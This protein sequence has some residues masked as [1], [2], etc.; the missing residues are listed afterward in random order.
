[1]A[2][3]TFNTAIQSSP[4]PKQEQVERPVK[5]Q[6]A[7]IQDRSPAE[8]KAIVEQANNTIATSSMSFKLREG[9]APVI[10]IVDPKTDEVIKEIPSEQMQKISEAI[11]AFANGERPQLNLIDEYI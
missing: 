5:E 11:Q 7:P 2:N 1:M 4:P 10:L 6:P 9:A 3:V 8:A